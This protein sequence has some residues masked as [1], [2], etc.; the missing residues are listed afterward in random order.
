MKYLIHAFFISFIILVTSLTYAADN[1]NIDKAS[2]VV[3]DVAINTK[4]LARYA[5]DPLL[6]P[7]K[8]TV[9]SSNGEV[10]LSG[11]VDSDVQ[12]ER[13]IIIAESTNGV[14]G[15][16]GK[17]LKVKSSDQPFTDTYI[18]AKI[19]GSLLKNEMVNGDNYSAW[20]I[21]VETENGVVFLTGKV[22]DNDQK[23]KVI[24]LVK[25]IEGVKNVQE[26]LKFE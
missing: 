6:N 14:K 19:K 15:V 26:D 21:H 10:A 5:N 4:I 18:T 20:A 9:S 13:A 22:K 16:N 1:S 12:F 24:T 7:F 2:N 11:Q 25:A 17:D 23:I 8:I 3:D